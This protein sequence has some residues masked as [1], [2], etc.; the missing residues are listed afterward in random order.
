MADGANFAQHIRNR[1]QFG[2]TWKKSALKIRAQAETHHGNFQPVCYMRQLPHLFGIKELRLVDE[3]TGDALLLVRCF[4]TCEQILTMRIQ[5]ALRRDAETG[6]DHAALFRVMRRSKDQRVHA[7]LAVIVRGLQQHCRL[8]GIHGGIGE[9]EFGHQALCNRTS[10][11]ARIKRSAPH[12]S[13][14]IHQAAAKYTY[15]AYP[16]GL[17]SA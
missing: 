16:P 3:N 11:A 4:D 5:L 13:Q 17:R 12:Y 10:A 15:P 6:G 14:V 8:A 2:R 1:E 7:A 9:I